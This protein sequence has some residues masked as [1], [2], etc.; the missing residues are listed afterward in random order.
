LVTGAML[1]RALRLNCACA[2]R[3]VSDQGTAACGEAEHLQARKHSGR[4]HLP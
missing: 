4:R 3:I 2:G 1:M